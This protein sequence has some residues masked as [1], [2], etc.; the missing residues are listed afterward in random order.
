MLPFPSPTPGLPSEP[1]LLPHQRVL[2]VVC[3]HRRHSWSGCVLSSGDT[4]CSAGQVCVCV[5]CLCVH[6]ITQHHPS[7]HTY[8]H[9][10]C[11]SCSHM[12]IITPSHTD[13]HTH[14]CA[15]TDTPSNVLCC[16]L[17]CHC[18]HL[19]ALTDNGDG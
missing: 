17:K 13:T 18:M 8:A 7:V 16:R 12:H 15:H 10:E 11:R 5:S 2:A 19:S 1:S 6:W 3:H 14:A 4:L 9:S